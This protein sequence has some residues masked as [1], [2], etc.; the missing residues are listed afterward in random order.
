[1][2][3]PDR[4][5]RGSEVELAVY[6]WRAGAPDRPTVVLVH[7]YPDNASVWS[8]VAPA[9]AG[10]CDVVAY[11]VRGAGRSSAPRRIA[12]YR[13][14]RL[15]EDLAAVVDAVSPGRPV[16]LVG[17]AWGSIQS[18]DALAGA[19]SRTRFASFTTISGPSLDHA[20]LWLRHRWRSRSHV[21]WA[22]G[23]RQLGRSWY[24]AMFQIPGLSALPWRLGL[25]ARWPRMLARREG[26]QIDADPM[27]RSD[28][29]HGV[30][31]YRANIPGHLR[32]PRPQRIELPV[33]LIVARRDPFMIP[34]LWD[35]LGDWVTDLQRREVDGG[36]W[37]PL[38][39]ASELVEWI[40][41][42]VDAVER[43]LSPPT[44][45]KGLGVEGLSPRP[46][47]G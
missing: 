7:G 44:N 28:G 38:T 1:V 26:V 32:R 40:A 16:H 17:H 22:R 30:K 29:I 9:L 43:R 20:A 10:R 15:N 4:Y 37:L 23:L 46:A 18:W 5:V 36:H 21:Q 24:I 6:R 12:D 47:S 35:E 25:H 39:H 31:L 19:P 8:R 42:F 3:E 11:D 2:I 27:R 13:I 14:E 41:G 34:E 33:Q 45:G